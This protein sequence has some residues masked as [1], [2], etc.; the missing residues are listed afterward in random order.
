MFEFVSCRFAAKDKFE[1]ERGAL[2]KE[3]LFYITKGEIQYVINQKFETAEE[4]D[5]VC[6]PSA[7]YFERKITKSLEFYHVRF[8]NPENHPFPIGKIHISDKPRLLSTLNYMCSLEHMPRENKNLKNH[9]LND[10]FVQFEVCNAITH[11]QKDNVVTKAIDYFHKIWIKK[12]RL[13]KRPKI[14]ESLFPVL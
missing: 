8:E 13:K 3:S 9:F 4:G 11:M 7:L 6:F 14:S 10:I 1:I 5:F 12:S 2:S